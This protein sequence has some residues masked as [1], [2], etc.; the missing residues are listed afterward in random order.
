MYYGSYTISVE[1]KTEEERDEQLSK[2]Y[3]SLNMI[4]YDGDDQLHCE[5]WEDTE[6]KWND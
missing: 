1:G 2:L 5:G 6:K 3:E 4:T